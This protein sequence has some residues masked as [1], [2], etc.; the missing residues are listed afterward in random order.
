MFTLH[1]L[2]RLPLQLLLSFILILSSVFSSICFAHSGEINKANL[3]LEN[4]VQYHL[5]VTV[6]IIHLLKK[7]QNIKGDDSEVI[8]ALNQLSFVQQKKLL[9]NLHEKLTQETFIRF[10]DLEHNVNDFSGLSL[11]QL[12]N[13]LKQ[14]AEIADTQATLHAVGEIP[15]TAENISIRFSEL[16]AHVQLSVVR[17]ETDLVSNNEYS[18]KFAINT[19][20]AGTV[21]NSVFASSIMVFKDY[22]VQGF[23]HIVPKGLDHILFVLALFLFAKSRTSLILQISAFT[24]AHTITLALGIYGVLQLSGAIVEPLIA[25]SIIY[26]ALENYYR[27]K[28]NNIGYTRMPVIFA[29]GL[30]HGLGFASVLR[31]VGLPE[32]QYALG[33]ISFNIGVELGQL[34]VI[35]IA[36]VF[37]AP[38]MKKQWYQSSVVNTLNITIAIVASYWFIERVIPF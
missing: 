32:S 12:K 13:I 7:Y 28:S 22:I 15:E 11:I 36:F 9:D 1:A 27:T 37:L 5:T 31:D 30:L 29:F 17:P 18:E 38:L 33:L 20:S 3:S 4:S 19:V 16:F 25:L 8:A 24:L 10:G 34:S 35:A 23:V 6:N 2:Q 26:V 14:S 21:T